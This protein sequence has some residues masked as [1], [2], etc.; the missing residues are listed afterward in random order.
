MAVFGIPNEEWGEEVKAVVQLKSGTIA[1][2]ELTEQLIE[3][4]TKHLA[5]QKIPRSIDFISELPRSQ[6]GKVQRKR[7][8]DSYWPT[9]QTIISS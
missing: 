2:T 1:S 5:K 7:L 4:T 6:A 9:Q 8:R 3:F